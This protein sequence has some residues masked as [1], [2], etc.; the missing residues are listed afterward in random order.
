[1]YDELTYRYPRT[2]GEAFGHRYHEI[3][4]DEPLGYGVLWWTAIALIWVATLVLLAVTK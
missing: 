1:M 4:D 2:M 3:E